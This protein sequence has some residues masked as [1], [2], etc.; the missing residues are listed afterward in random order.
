VEPGAERVATIVFVVA[1]AGAEIVGASAGWVVGAV[2]DGLILLTL[3]NAP[4]LGLVRPASRMPAV[5]GLVPLL[6]IVSVA[7]P[8]RQIP[9]IAWYPLVGA[10]LLLA[11]ALAAQQMVTSLPRLRLDRNGALVQAAIALAGIPLGGLAYLILRPRPLESQLSWHVVVLDSIVLLFFPALVEELVFRWLLQD[12]VLRLLGPAG[13][14]LT[15]ALY[16]STYAG[17]LSPG[18]ALFMGSVGLAFAIAVR[19]TALLWGVIGAHALLDVG[20]LVVW[21]AV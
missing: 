21:P 1:I 11:A 4:A 19:R 16:A 15:S 6:R 5:L 13:L 20:L 7:V 14:L 2:L 10:P 17:S 18:F 8:V 9:E 3:L 12:V